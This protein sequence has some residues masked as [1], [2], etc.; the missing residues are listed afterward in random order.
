MKREI[1]FSELRGSYL[2]DY[3]EMVQIG[4]KQL[5]NYWESWDEVLGEIEF[6]VFSDFRTAGARMY[7]YYP[8]DDLF[9]DFANPFSKIA[10]LI[11]YKQTNILEFESKIEYLRSRGWKVY[12]LESKSVQFSA[13]D[14]YLMEQVGSEFDFENMTSED[15][16]QF[17]ERFMSVNSECFAEWIK[18]YTN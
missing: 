13:M 11:R 14:L 9:V 16:E 10:L 15:R 6:K 12:T 7:P 2:N 4:R 3:N 8:V 17:Y 5:N 1:N 18:N